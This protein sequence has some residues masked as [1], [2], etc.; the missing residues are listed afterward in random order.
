MRLIR[1]KYMARVINALRFVRVMRARVR[2]RGRDRG[3]EIQARA[4]A[5]ICCL[6]ILIFL[7]RLFCD[8]RRFARSRFPPRA[9]S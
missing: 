2:D 8:P 9:R 7:V 3:G 6:L 1:G 5:A 4:I